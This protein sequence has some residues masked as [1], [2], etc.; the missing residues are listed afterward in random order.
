MQYPYM[1]VAVFL[2][3]IV[4][5]S[6]LNVLIYRLPRKLSII[7]PRSK[8]P[9]CGSEA[10]IFRGYRHNKNSVKRMRLCKRCGR[11]FT[12]DDGFLR[13]RFSAEDI[14]LAVSLR[15][16]GF[17]LAEVQLHLKRRGVR[18]SRWTISKWESRF[19]KSK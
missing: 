1:L 13:M 12:P 10:V 19:S 4:I 15:K 9:Q 17:S 5:G 3:G 6:F 7:R 2:Y 11:K 18:V 14:K 16:R 8:C